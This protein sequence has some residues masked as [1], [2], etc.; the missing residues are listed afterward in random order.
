MVRAK[1]VESVVSQ[2]SAAAGI[3]AQLRQGAAETVS[4]IIVEGVVQGLET[5]AQNASLVADPA[6]AVARWTLEIMWSH[7]VAFFWTLV[8]RCSNYPFDAAHWVDS[9]IASGF[10]YVRLWPSGNEQWNELLVPLLV[11]WGTL[12]A[13]LGAL[14]LSS[15]RAWRIMQCKMKVA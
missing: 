9:Q 11:G 4:N 8:G 15:R 1:V 14:A 6:E 7:L 10:R 3:G 5:L 2:A 12:L 13:A